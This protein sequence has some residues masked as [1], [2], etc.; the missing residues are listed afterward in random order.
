MSDGAGGTADGTVQ[1]SVTP[2]NDA[3]Q[4]LGESADATEDTALLIDPAD[5]L[6]ND[7]DIDDDQTT[8]TITAVG[9]CQHGS[10]SLVTLEA[11]V[12]KI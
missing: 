9:S 3:P 7:T 2:V 5:L 10:V 1:L 4:A 11:G 8:L 6:K 12:Q